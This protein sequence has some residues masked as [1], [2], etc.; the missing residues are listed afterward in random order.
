MERVNSQIT[1]QLNNMD[2]NLMTQVPA[3]MSTQVHGPVMTQPSE[4]NYNQNYNQQMAMQQNIH[5][6]YVP[7]TSQQPSHI[8]QTPHQA[9]HVQQIPQQASYEQQLPKIP[10]Q[11]KYTIHT[12][13]V[14]TSRAITPTACPSE[15][16]ERDED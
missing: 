1:P 8:Q 4:Q 7:A 14:A 13:Q 15:T 10:Q 16:E 6:Q 2:P 12:S 11:P 9:S 3:M 5:S